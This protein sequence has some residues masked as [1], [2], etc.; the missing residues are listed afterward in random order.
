MLRLCL[1]LSLA[2]MLLPA[3]ATAATY[4]GHSMAMLR[5][6]AEALDAELEV[7]LV[8]RQAA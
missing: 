8:P 7:R 2:G 3:T 4:R 1:A 6:V 5:R